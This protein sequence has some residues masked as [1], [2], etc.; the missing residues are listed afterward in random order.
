[1]PGTSYFFML[2]PRQLVRLRRRG[3][4]VITNSLNNLIIPLFS[5][6]VSWLV[7]RRESVGLWGAFVEVM[8]VVQLAAHIMHWGHKEYLL[9]TFSLNPTTLAPAWQTALLTRLL[10]F[11]PYLPILFL[12]NW[13]GERVAA[14]FLW[15]VLLVLSQSIEVLV[16]YRR[17]FGT[18]LLVELSQSLLLLLSIALWSGQLTVDGLLWLF[19]LTTGVKTIWLW[20]YFRGVVLKRG[21]GVKVEWG[22]FAAAF[23]FFLIGLSG[24]LNSRIDLYSVSYFLDEHEVG[25]YQILINLLLYLQA[26]SNF[27]LLPFIKTLYRVSQP[28]TFKVAVRLLGI[29]VLITPPALLVINLILSQV[30]DIHLNNAYWLVG[31]LYVLPIYFYVPFVYALYKG[32][33]Q[34]IVVQVSLIGALLNVLLNIWLIPAWGMLGALLATAIVQWLSLFVYVYTARQTNPKIEY[35]SP[36]Q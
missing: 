34:K 19:T 7:I 10:L 22:Y 16:L 28:T 29:G 9:R 32:N 25:Q 23:T 6:L 12:F 15:T 31:A 13:S 5:V 27:I 18:A 3:R 17:A 14:A 8:I 1:M 33:R 2:T 35:N 20:G 30:L 4:I 26:A 11:I 24:T 36:Q 21:T